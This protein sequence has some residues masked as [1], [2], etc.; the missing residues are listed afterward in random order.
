MKK[1]NDNEKI[2]QILRHALSPTEEPSYMLN[3]QILN[4][5]KEKKDMKKFNKKKAPVMAFTIISVVALGAVSAFGAIKYLSPTNVATE[6]EDTKLADAFS[7]KNAIFIN[8]SQVVGNTKYSLLGMISGKSLSKYVEK[9]NRGKV[10]ND[11]TYI[12]TSIENTDGSKRPAISDKDYSGNDMIVTPLVKGI[13]PSEL[14]I[15][16][17]GGGYSEIVENGVQYRI[18]ECDT[19]EMF[20]DKGVYLAICDNNSFNTIYNYNKTTGAITPNKEYDGLNLLFDLPMDKAKANPSKAKKYLEELAANKENDNVDNTNEDDTEF[21]K[22]ITEISSWPTEKIIKNCTKLDKLT[23]T[24]TPD[25]DGYIE[26]SYTI[27]EDGQS[28]EARILASE[29]L[30]GKQ[31]GEQ[32]LH[33]ISG[34]DEDSL[35]VEMLCKNGDGNVEL[36]VYKFGK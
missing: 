13:N 30:K 7:S 24:L 23:Q 15:Y 12:V 36:R 2:D 4:I 3:K 28:S 25:K 21:D 11:K 27:G 35:Y 34:S 32:V 9:D 8:K 1:N 19:M 16:T 10:K 18:L 17:M 31:V 29:V 6:L 26:Y 5:V 14:N 33:N 22:L 20:A